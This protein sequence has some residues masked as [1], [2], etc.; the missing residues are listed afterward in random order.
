MLVLVYS[1]NDIY[2]N[3]LKN[4]ISTTTVLVYNS[5]DIYFNCGINKYEDTKS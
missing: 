3:V 1:S 2:F 4:W 5:N